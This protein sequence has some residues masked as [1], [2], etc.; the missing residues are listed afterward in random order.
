MRD[1]AQGS[2]ALCLIPLPLSLTPE[3]LF[4]YKNKMRARAF[5]TGLLANPRILIGFCL[6]HD[7]AKMQT[8]GCKTIQ[9]VSAPVNV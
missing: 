1:P 8:A 7:I 9:V 6:F 4:Q 2:Q 3:I 5:Q